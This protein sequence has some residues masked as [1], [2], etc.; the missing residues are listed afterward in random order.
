MVETIFQRDLTDAG[1]FGFTA[2]SE[3][4]MG[5]R[6][7]RYHLDDSR[8]ISPYGL[9]MPP[10]IADLLDI[11]A[12][13]MWADRNCKRPKEYGNFMSERGWVRQYDLT[14]G[15]R[16]PDIWNTYSVKN[17]LTQLLTWLTEDIWNIQ[18][19]QQQHA[20]RHSDLQ[21]ALF[22]T[23]PTDALI[24]LYSGGLDSLAGTVTLLQENPHSTVILMSAVSDRL[25]GVVKEQVR[26]LQNTYGINRVQHALMPFHVAHNDKDRKET[27]ET[28]ERTRGFL[29]WSFGVAEAVACN[30]S[31]VVTCENGVGLLNLP[32]NRHQLGAQNTRA[33]HPKTLNLMNSLVS[34]LEYGHIRCRAPFMLKTK[35]ELCLQTRTSDL[36]TLC[37]TTV[38][39]DS[40]PLRVARPDGYPDAQLHCGWCTSCLFRRQS[41]F[42]AGLQEEDARTPYQYDV[43]KSQRTTNASRLE[44]LK[45]LLDQ[46]YSIQKACLSP[47]ADVAFIQEFPEIVPACYAIEQ[48]P[49][50]FGSSSDISF[51]DELVQLFLRY[52]GEWELFPYTLYTR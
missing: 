10:I 4:I 7:R 12:A 39:C 49:D 35:A 21:S 33:V 23:S 1:L 40:F 34:L 45:F 52:V 8:L 41:L 38:S 48:F 9:T 43:C 17:T 26:K 42:A 11:A 15:V 31:S 13:I 5:A 36:S 6:E 37:R 24:A 47:L 19:Q 29:F 22:S 14:L 50:L 51:M 16:K 2:L 27:T 28:T 44:R 18:F 30:A 25:S 20:R 32:L 3:T 46:R